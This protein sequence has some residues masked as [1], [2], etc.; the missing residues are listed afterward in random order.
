MRDRFGLW[1]CAVLSVL[2]GPA[3][4]EILPMERR[5]S[6][7]SQAAPLYVRAEPGAQA[8][9]SLFTGTSRASLFAPMAVPQHAPV[10]PGMTGG[11][12]A[13]LRSLIAQAEA[14]AKGY[15]AVQYGAWVLPGGPPTTLTLGEI[16]DWIDATPGM[17]HAIG[18]YQ[19]IP[20]TLRRLADALAL[21]D[22]TVFSPAV[23]DA[24][25]DLLLKE[26]GITRFTAG[27]LSRHGFMNNLA[28]IWAG[29]PNDTGKSHY[30]GYAGNK[31]TMSWSRF[32]AE[33]AR[34]FP[35]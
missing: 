8:S 18:R 30:H 7:L 20:P 35:G 14:G 2:M 23:Q 21:P 26:A 1:L 10:L 22:S 12:V 15:D 28:K 29:L 24:L 16:Y 6:L 34:I 33:M 11:A 25:A 31:A 19:F 4:A 13:Q 5:A 3:W 27:D 32:D 17:P 9:P